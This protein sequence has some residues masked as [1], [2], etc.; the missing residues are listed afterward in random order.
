MRNLFQFPNFAGRGLS[1][2]MA[3]GVLSYKRVEV[4]GL[5]PQESEIYSKMGQ[6][7]AGQYG[8]GR[9][10]GVLASKSVKLP[11]RMKIENSKIQNLFTVAHLHRKGLVVQTWSLMSSLT[12]N[13][14]IGITAPKERD[15]TQKGTTQDW[16]GSPWSIQGVLSS[17]SVKFPPQ[18]EM[19]IQ[20]SESQK[21]CSFPI[22]LDGVCRPYIVLD[23]ISYKR[24]IVSGMRPQESEV[25]PKRGQCGTGKDGI[26]K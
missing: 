19:E 4:L 25:Y 21:L 18:M 24:F 1:L 5:W 10:R 22:S 20:N 15:L 2:D 23:V 14:S 17:M 9:Y 8:H 26:G 11:T 13:S 16:E 6:G 3:L 7:G 12:I